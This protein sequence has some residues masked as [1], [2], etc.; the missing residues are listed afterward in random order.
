MSVR[1]SCSWIVSKRINVSSKFF[2]HREAKPFKFFRT[3]RH[4][5]IHTGTPLTGSLNAGGVGRNRNRRD[6][7]DWWHAGPVNNKCN[8]PPCSLPHLQRRISEAILITTKREERTQYVLVYVA[9][10]LKRNLRSMYC[11]IEA[12]K[13]HEASSGLFATAELLVKL[14]AG[15]LSW[16]CSLMNGFQKIGYL[17][18][19]LPTQENPIFGSPNRTPGAIV[20]NLWDAQ[21]S[22]NPF[23]VLAMRPK[24]TD[25][26]I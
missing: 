5:N 13:R 14:T 4:G 2:H 23:R 20:T 25:R 15:R 18:E 17:R 6:T 19:A 22:T 8:D 21:F 10:N 24:Q 12:N 11:T 16:K 3:K 7:A 9:V 26:Q 1:L